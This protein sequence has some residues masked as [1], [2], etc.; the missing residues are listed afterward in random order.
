[1][2]SLGALVLAVSAFAFAAG[3]NHETC[4]SE[5]PLGPL[6]PPTTEPVGFCCFRTPQQ[7][8]QPW[9]SP[10]QA[11]DHLTQDQHLP[12]DGWVV[13]RKTATSVTYYRKR[14]HGWDEVRV[15]EANGHYWYA[16]YSKDCG[17]KDDYPYRPAG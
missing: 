8:P 3:C 10:R 16:D 15:D 5:G 7:G 14:P 4:G 6:L 11:L 12:T 9:D 17:T 13:K 2:R 1:V